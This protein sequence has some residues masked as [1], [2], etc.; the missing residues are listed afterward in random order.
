MQAMSRGKRLTV[1]EDPPYDALQAFVRDNHIAL[2]GAQR[3]PLEELVFAIKDVWEVKGSRVGNGHPDF[4]AAQDL[5]DSTAS[6]VSRLLDSGADLVGKTM[7]DELCYSISGENWHYGS[8]I[9]PRD[10]WR[11]TGG[12][13]SGSA[14]ATAGGLVDFALGSDCLGSVR[15]PCSYNGLLGMRPTYKRVP[16]DGEA[17]FCPSMDVVGFM[18]GDPGTFECVAQVML[19]DDEDDVQITRAYAA[20]DCFNAVDRSVME[21]LAP[22]KA[23]VDNAIG[24]AEDVEIAPGGLAKWVEIFRVIQGYEVWESYRAWID[25]AQP[26]LTPGPRDRL[27]WASTITEREYEGAKSAREGV[28]SRFET[29]V[30]PGSVLVL[31]TAASIAPLRGT[32]VEQISA[33]RLQS[34]YLL[35]ISPLTG[36]PQINLPLVSQDGMPLGLALI[37]P[38]GS[39][40]QLARIAADLVRS[41]QEQSH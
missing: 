14:A 41:N 29:I 11:Y 16:D 1:S 7:C 20:S 34:T 26:R 19:G 28:V 24:P 35:C 18:A 22:A 27:A 3:G 37:G 5:S 23:A 33:T 40:L 2:H 30:K 36:A 9:N 21:A 6:I 25:K 12:S 13:S 4:L 32:P 39:D 31:P 15:V 8:P 17:S 38:P 10:P